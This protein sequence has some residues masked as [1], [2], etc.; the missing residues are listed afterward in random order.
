LQQP[1]LH[2]SRYFEQHKERYLDGLLDVSLHGDWRGWVE[3][4]LIAVATESGRAVGTV[5]KLLALRDDY[6]TR[7]RRSPAK[8][9][10]EVTDLLFSGPVQSVSSIAKALD[11]EYKTARNMV[12]LLVADGVLE[13]TT[14]KQRNRIYL[15]PEIM[16][17]LEE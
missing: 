1:L 8:R 16:Q 12:G 10:T 4:F 2:L 6:R 14:G 9:M 17:L 13:E 7:F 5:R 11:M 3:L 15:A